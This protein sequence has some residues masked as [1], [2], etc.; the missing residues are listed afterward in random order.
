MFVQANQGEEVTISVSALEDDP[1][2]GEIGRTTFSFRV[3]DTLVEDLP[4]TCNDEN[5]YSLREYHS[6]VMTIEGWPVADTENVAIT[7]TDEHGGTELIL[8]GN[9]GICL[10]RAFD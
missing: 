9:T 10:R 5:T 6:L 8:T 1:G 7:T 4:I 2:C 3:P